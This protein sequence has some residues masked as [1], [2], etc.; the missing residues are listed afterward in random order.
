MGG[1]EAAREQLLRLARLTISEAL[2]GPLYPLHAR[3]ARLVQKDDVVIGYNYDVLV[4]NAL[5][6]DGKI[7]EHARKTA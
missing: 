7:N 6:L 2:K 3:L 1:F 5:L 4:D